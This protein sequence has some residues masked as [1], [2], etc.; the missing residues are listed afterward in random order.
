LAA[1]VIQLSTDTTT[2]LLDLGQP[3]S[4]K[5]RQIDVATLQPDAVIVSHPHQD[6]FGLIDELD[7]IVPVY[8]SSLGKSLIDATRV[9]IGRDRHI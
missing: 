2:I 4:M 3:L 6:H 1:R 8:I 7:P 9:F 5:S